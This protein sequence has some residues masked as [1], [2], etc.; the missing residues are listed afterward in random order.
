METRTPALSAI[1]ETTTSP[2]S[3]QVQGEFPVGASVIY[4]LHG[5]CSV[6]AIESRDIGNE[7]IRFYKLEVQKSALS[8]SNRQDPAIWIPI[9]S[10]KDRGLRAPMNAADAEKVLATLASREYYFDPS[11][12]WT[13]VYQKLEASIRQEGGIGLAKVASFLHVLK[14]KQIVPTSEVIRFGETVNKLLFRELTEATGTP[15]RT[16]EDKINKG[17]RQKLIPDN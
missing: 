1:V 7:N 13:A 3:S 12:S 9:A 15:I 5:K 16:L 14:K 4:G 8:R 2:E 11:E 6:V 17:F 10:S